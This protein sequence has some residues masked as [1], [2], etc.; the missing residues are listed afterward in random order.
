MDAL[1]KNAVAILAFVIGIAW[2]F[3][4]TMEKYGIGKAFIVSMLF[5]D[6]FLVVFLVLGVDR[7][8]F[9][10][11]T[12]IGSTTVTAVEILLLFK[13]PIT[14]YLIAKSSKIVEVLG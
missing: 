10:I 14:A 11:Q 7:P 8:L 5:T 12:R 2:I 4:K 9:M 6:I 3:T 1:I 13:M